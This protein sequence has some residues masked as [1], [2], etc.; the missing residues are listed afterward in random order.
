MHLKTYYPL[1]KF[2]PLSLSGTTCMLHCRH[3]DATY[4]SG[5]LAAETPEALLGRGRALRS[6]GAIGVLL[7]GGSAEQGALL[8]LASLTDAI[9]QLKQ[10]TGLILNLHPGLIEADTARRLAVDFASLDIP[11]TEV[12]RNVL[13]LKAT[14]ADY[15]ATY[16]TLCAAGIEVVP[17]ITVYTGNEAQLLR[18]IA[19]T[20]STPH[21]IVVLVFTPTPNTPLAEAPAPAPQTVAKVITEVQTLFPKAEM[22]LGCMRPRSRVVREAIEW[23]ALQAG[24]TRMELPSQKV[25]HKAREAGYEITAFEACCALPESY[26]P[27][28]RRSA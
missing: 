12:I 22:A 18:P 28:A 25:L 6:R 5:M 4:L 17:H 10:E 19:G 15:I 26:E 7:S 14:T 8:N 27:L 3:C 16:H 9:R 2:P 1:P 11:S 21:V 23:A 20:E 24:V 13:G